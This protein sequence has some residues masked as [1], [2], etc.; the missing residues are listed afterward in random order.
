MKSIREW[1][2]PVEPR[3]ALPVEDQVVAAIINNGALPGFRGTLHRKI[4]AFPQEIALVLRRF[5]ALYLHGCCETGKVGLSGRLSNPWKFLVHSNMPSKALIFIRG[6]LLLAILLQGSCREAEKYEKTEAI[7]TRWAGQ[8][9]LSGPEAGSRLRSLRYILSPDGAAERHLLTKSNRWSDFQLEE[10]LRGQWS[11]GDRFIRIRFTDGSE[12]IT[13]TFDSISVRA[14]P[15]DS[16]R[17][18]TFWI[19]REAPERSLKRIAAF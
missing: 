17:L 12:R 3:L 18:D 7:E 5:Y 14:N 11:S 4:I 13:E 2:W 15:R 9:V 10:I 1:N 8:Y 6:S 16:T 19:Q